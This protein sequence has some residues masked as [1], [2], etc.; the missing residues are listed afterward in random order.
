MWD[1]TGKIRDLSM[2]FRSGAAVLTLVINEVQS[3]ADCFDELNGCEKLTIRLDRWRK[4]RSLDANAYF[5]VLADRLA[6]A[7]GISKEEIYRNAVRD[8][9]GNTETVCIRADAAPKFREAWERNGLGWISEEFPAIAPGYVNVILYYGSSTFDTAQMSR[10]IN[11]I[12]VPDCKAVGVDTMT[13]D[14]ISEMLSRWEDYE[15]HR[16]KR[17]G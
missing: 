2:E 7:T 11:D 5:W 14:E 15:K 10:L 1:F 17:Q 6:A 9:G 3:I 8:I 4:K 13:P 12:M 16:T